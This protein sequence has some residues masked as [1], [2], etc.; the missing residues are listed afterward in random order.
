MLTTHKIYDAFY[1]NYTSQKAFLHSHSYTGNALVCRTA[2]ATLTIFE[3]RNVLEN[4]TRLAAKMAEL[5]KRFMYANTHEKKGVL[6]R[7]LGNV[8]YL[9]HLTSLHTKN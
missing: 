5:S 7:P 9:S 1:D 4:N 8:I 3:T 2:L 6:M